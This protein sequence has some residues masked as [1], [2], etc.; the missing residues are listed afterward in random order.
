MGTLQAPLGMRG[1]TFL[2]RA[3]VL[4]L[5][6]AAATPCVAVAAD[7]GTPIPETGLDLGVEQ[8]TTRTPS[9]AWEWRGN[10]GAVL[11]F[12]DVSSQVRLGLR[13]TDT[14]RLE[15]ASARFGLGTL[16][17]TEAQALFWNGR[18][19]RGP[20]S[21]VSISFA[22]GIRLDALADRL[23][24]PRTSWVELGLQSRPVGTDVAGHTRMSTTLVLAL[25][26]DLVGPAADARVS[27]A[28][29]G[30]R[31]RASAALGN[32]P[33]CSLGTPS[34]LFSGRCLSLALAVEF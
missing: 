9:G 27:R 20:N 3:V 12:L 15:H 21:E 14:G 1:T 11:P 25:D 4:G 2:G 24:V 26:F 7:G 23:G 29:S 19:D 16:D 13:L 22:G 30:L 33:G 17:L 8:R 28:G 5:A 10:G 31:I 6:L 32:D 18:V 34:L